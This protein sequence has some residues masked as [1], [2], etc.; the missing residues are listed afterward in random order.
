MPVIN[1][2]DENG[3]NKKVNGKMYYTLIWFLCINKNIGGKKRRSKPN[4]KTN[5]RRTNMRTNKRLK[6]YKRRR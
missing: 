5:K 4:R 1:Y 2:N 6:T 3:I